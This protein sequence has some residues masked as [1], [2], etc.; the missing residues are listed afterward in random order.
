MDTPLQVK[1]WAGGIFADSLNASSSA[2]FW[3]TW[4]CTKVSGS[5]LQSTMTGQSHE[6]NDSRAFCFSKWCTQSWKNKCLTSESYAKSWDNKMFHMFTCMYS[7]ARKERVYLFE[8]L[9]GKIPFI[10]EF[11]IHTVGKN[12]TIRHWTVKIILKSLFVFRITN[13]MVT[14]Y[15]NEYLALHQFQG[16]CRYL[17]LKQFAKDW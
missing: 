6:R 9:D 7:T 14:Q 8:Q 13:E 16:I 10:I 15:G 4:N 5:G 11:D 17:S 12:P 3:P 1:N 2:S